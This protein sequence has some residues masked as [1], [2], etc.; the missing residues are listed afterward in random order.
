MLNCWCSAR[1]RGAAPAH[2][3]DPVRASGP[4]VARRAGPTAPLQVLDR[5][6]PR[7]ARDAAGLAPQADHEQVRHEQ[8]PQARPPA[9]GPE[10]RPP[11]HSPREPYFRAEQDRL[12][13]CGGGHV[14]VGA[15]PLGADPQPLLDQVTVVLQCLGLDRHRL[16]TTCVRHESQGCDRIAPKACPVAS[17]PPS[18]FRTRRERKISI[19]RWKAGGNDSGHVVGKPCTL[20]VKFLLLDC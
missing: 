10:R 5:N 13:P 12:A 2:W 7:H 20:V 14:V 19:A 16:G 3:P 4:G 6:L 9:D 17:A 1:E 18:L 15:A 8:W 11:C